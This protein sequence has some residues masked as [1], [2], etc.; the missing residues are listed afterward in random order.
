MSDRGTIW[1]L[2]RAIARACYGEAARL[3]ALHDE[4]MKW[5]RSDDGKFNMDNETFALQAQKTSLEIMAL[6]NVASEAAKEFQYGVDPGR[7]R[8]TE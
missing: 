6:G 5:A 7:D 2:L 4:T 8:Q 3:A 1:L